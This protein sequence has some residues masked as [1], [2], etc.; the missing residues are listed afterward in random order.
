MFKSITLLLLALIAFTNAI[1]QTIITGKVT[2]QDGKP[3]LMTNVVL[4]LPMD[5]EPIKIV[6]ADNEGRYRI[7][8]DSTGLWL[9]DFTGVYHKHHQVAI[10]TYRPMA[11]DLDVRLG[12]YEYLKDFSQTKVVGS[13][14]GWSNQTAIPMQEQPGGVFSAEIGSNFDSLAYRLINVAQ[15]DLVE[16]TQADS[17]VFNKFVGYNSIV[18]VNAG[19]VKITFDPAKLVMSAKPA[20]VA[21]T[22]SGSIEAKFAATYQ[23]MM[24]ELSDFEKEYTDYRNSG[25]DMGFFKYQARGRIDSV[26]ARLKR[27]SIPIL[28]QELYINYLLLGPLTSNLD[29]AIL[30]N[31]LTE[32]P[33]SSALW[34]IEPNLIFSF[35]MVYAGIPATVQQTYINRLLDENPYSELKAMILLSELRNAKYNNDYKKATEY[36]DL[37]VNKYG[38]TQSGKLAAARFSAETKIAVGKPVPVFSVK[39]LE[40]STK[41]L[42]NESF[43]GKYYLI[44]FWATWCGPCVNEMENLHKAYAKFKDKNLEILSIS[45]DEQVT[46]V[47]KFRKEKWPMPW[48]HAFIGYSS[49]SKI[50]KDFEVIFIPHPILVDASGTIVAMDIELRSQNL[51]KTLEKYLGK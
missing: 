11:L 32:I 30:L 1:A 50:L 25:K 22:D 17:F 48:V 38:N 37:L 29:S 39:S 47:V 4:K 16:G 28:R 3:M 19:K 23:E 7:P 24:D 13:F 2:D 21:F 35:V 6:T 51:E 41:V 27:E 26:L 45:E 40:D 43:K 8:I 18:H 10:Y 14:N 20:R 36:Y 15:G 33:P 42:T 46:D 34:T 31:A 9:L 44:D 49:G 12:T 5:S